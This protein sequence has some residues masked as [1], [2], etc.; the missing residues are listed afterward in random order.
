MYVV[1][2]R[3]GLGEYPGY[4]CYDA[5]RPSWLPYWI[6]SINESLCKYSPST[7]AGNVAACATGN[8]SCGAPT[9]Q[10]AN[11]SL[12]GPGVTGPGYTANPG[13]TNVPI[14]TGSDVLDPSTNTCVPGG[15]LAARFVNLFGG[16]APNQPSVPAIATGSLSTTAMIAIGL[17]AGVGLL[18][19]TG[20]SGGRRRR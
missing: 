17:A 6:D 13:P 2:H 19:L 1:R 8:P 10:Q 14:C 7:I 3:R 12:S 11:P 20:S 18:V 4:Y 16:A 15:G 5:N 9:P